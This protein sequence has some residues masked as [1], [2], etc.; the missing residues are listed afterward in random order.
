MILYAVS[1]VV[2]VDLADEWSQWMQT[3]HIPDVM[4]TRVWKEARFTRLHEPA[5]DSHVT[6]IT[7]YMCESHREYDRYRSEF[8][9]AL[10]AHHNE[11]FGSKVMA[12]RSV[13]EVVAEFTT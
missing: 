4:A 3:I 5:M 13:Q 6:Y 9:A 2:P 12:S 7:S 1:V 10:Q 11:L 8:A